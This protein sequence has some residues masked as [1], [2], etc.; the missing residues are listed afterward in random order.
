MRRFTLSV[1]VILSVLTASAATAQLRGTGRLQG[2]V[3][4]KI[5]G[6]PIQGA[7]VTVSLAARTTTTPIV[8]KTDA[9]GHWSALGLTSGQWN[10][11][12]VAPGYQ[13][14]RG[15]ATVSEMQQMPA[16]Q[17]AMVAEDK[18]ES[19]QAVAETPLIPK[20]A[21]DAIT[22]GQSLLKVHAGD[23]VTD[24]AG[25]SHQVTAD[26]ARDATKRALADFEKALPMVPDDKPQTKAVRDQL[27]QVMAQTYYRAGDLA[28][29]IAMLE[30]VTTADPS[31]VTAA[32]LLANLYLQNGQLDAGKALLEK[33]PP[34]TIKDSTVYVNVGILFLNKK[35]PADA[36]TYFTK[37]IALEP[38]LGDSYYYR[39]LAY[40]QL[41]KTPEARADF[42]QVVALA[43]DSP[44]AKDAKSM[45]AALPAK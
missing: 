7:V 1:A 15:S 29:A 36:V 31:N 14:T 3:T 42:E 43:P 6:K 12:I 37:A 25:A 8:S 23:T 27:M 33:L 17:T 32:A 5:S 21:A 39:G 2:T 24:A 41:K 9:R 16:I 35:S 18:Q 13:T 4:D 20:E 19:P 10:I 38:K 11:D 30:N 22:E 26:E 40:T 44:E 45:L 34:D 28:K